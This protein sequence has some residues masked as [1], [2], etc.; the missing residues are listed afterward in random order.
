MEKCALWFVTSGFGMGEG[1][2]GGCRKCR[3]GGG[4]G[5]KRGG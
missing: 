4:I 3:R 2:G 5:S 1:W